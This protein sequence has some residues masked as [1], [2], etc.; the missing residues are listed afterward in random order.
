MAMVLDE[1]ML[2]ELVH[3]KIDAPACSADHR[4]QS[5]L[6]YSGKSVRLALIPV[7]CEQKKNAGESPLTGVRNLV[8]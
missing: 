5:P 6:R 7:P 3:K 1:S 4:C 2:S 8:D